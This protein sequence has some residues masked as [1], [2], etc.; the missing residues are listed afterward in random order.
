MGNSWEDYYKKVSKRKEHPVLRIALDMLSKKGLAY[1]LGAGAGVDS[2][3]L[4]R[5]GW[6][7]I[8]VDQEQASIDFINKTTKDS[9]SVKAVR[10]NFESIDL[11]EC[12]LIFGAA[13]F[14][15]CRAEEF[16]KFWE[17]MKNALVKDGVLAG[18]LFGVNDTWAIKNDKTMTFLDHDSI[19]KLFKGF[20]IMYFDEVEEDRKTALGNL[21][22]WHIYSFVLKRI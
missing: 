13:S 18:N 12:D 21:K 2:N 11:K 4:A 14:P 7:V 17:N 9:R 10:S 3:Y 19:S 20:D 1:D 8:A 5:N 22:H 15:F 16:N 6:R